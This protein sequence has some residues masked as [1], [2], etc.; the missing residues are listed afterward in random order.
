[1]VDCLSVS[2]F[3]LMYAIIY[4]ISE[5]E[6]IS[7]VE[8]TLNVTDRTNRLTAYFVDC[9]SAITIYWSKIVNFSCPTNIELYRP[10]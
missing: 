8:E 2:E 1:V 7:V 9:F 3:Q 5:L 4:D 10:W 6:K